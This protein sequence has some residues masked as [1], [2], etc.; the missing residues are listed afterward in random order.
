CSCE[1]PVN[2]DPVSLVDQPRLMR[3]VCLIFRLLGF[4]LAGHVIGHCLDGIEDVLLHPLA[5]FQRVVFHRADNRNQPA[6]EVVRVQAFTHKWWSAHNV[7]LPLVSRVVFPQFAHTY[8]PIH[9]NNRCASAR[10]MV[11][12]LTSMPASTASVCDS[13]VRWFTFGKW[14]ICAL[15]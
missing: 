12:G 2:V 9:P 11:S 5:E 4:D 6:R 3:R 14:T 7:G 1:P 13:P 15:P 8:L 10:L